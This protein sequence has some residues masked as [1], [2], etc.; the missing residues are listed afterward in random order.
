MPR[1]SAASRTSAKVALRSAR[2][3]ATVS[4]MPVMISIVHSKSSCLAFGCSP[5]G[6]PWPS[7][8]RMSEA[9]LTSSPVSWSTSSSSTSTP[10]VGA[11][12]PLNSMCTLGA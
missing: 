5:S 11:G 4:Q 3:S 12:D 2:A 9:A 7:S 1:R 6:W 10:R 8:L